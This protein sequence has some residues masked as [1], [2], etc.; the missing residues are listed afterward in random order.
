MSLRT[1]SLQILSILSDNLK[2]PEPQLVRSTYLADKMQVSVKEIQQILKVMDSLGVI[3]SDVEGQY[4]LITP[5]G[6]RDLDR[7][8]AAG[9]RR[10]ESLQ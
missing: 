9:G 8:R 2:N 6:M 4:S 5:E 3:Q 7:C 10:A 1:K